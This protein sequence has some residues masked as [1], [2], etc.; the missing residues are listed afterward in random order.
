MTGSQHFSPGDIQF[1]LVY[2][3]GKCAESSYLKQ[4]LSWNG[5]R[6]KIKHS[7]LIGLYAEGG[8]KDESLKIIRI[9][10]L[11]DNNFHAWKSIPNALFLDLGVNAVFYDNFKPY[12][13]CMKKIN[14]I[15]LSF[16]S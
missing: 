6:P 13:Y 15:L 2:D 9:R 12:T 3:R 11:L 14:L 1:Q 7:T 5:R 16:N 8:Y 4:N 10:R